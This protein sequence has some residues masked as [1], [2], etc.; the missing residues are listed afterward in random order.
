MTMVLATFIWMV[1]VIIL[2]EATLNQ[3]HFAIRRKLKNGLMKK[4]CS[5]QGQKVKLATEEQLLYI[6]KATEQP[7]V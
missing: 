5:C 3:H 1:Q 7:T 6:V 2:E 4:V